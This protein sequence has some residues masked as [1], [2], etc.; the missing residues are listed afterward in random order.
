M[1]DS[2]PIDIH[3]AGTLAGAFA[4]RV[5]RSPGKTAYREFDHGSEAW[6]EYSWADTAALAARWQQGLRDLGL[7][8]GDRVALMLRNCINWIVFDQAALGLGLITVPLYT[9]DRADSMAYI[10]EDC[11]ARVLLIEGEDQWK[12]LRKVATRLSAL[13]AIIS[14]T[15][16]DAGDSGL[17]ILHAPAWL[18]QAGAAFTSIDIE[19]QALAT[20]VYTSGTTGHPKGVMLSHYNILWNVQAGLARLP[21][22]LDDE[23]LSFLPLSHTFERTG[24]YYLTIVSGSTVSF[25]RSVTLLAEDLVNIR[26]TI[27]IAVPRIFERIYTRLQHKLAQGPG[28]A[29]RLFATAV[30]TGWR[31]FEHQQ[32]R[33][34][35]TP[36]L[37]LWPLWD[38]LVARKVR[39]RLGG[40]LKVAVSG[41]AA[42]SPDIARTFI[43]LGIPIVQGYGLTETSPIVSGNRLENNIPASVGQPL[44]GVEVR[45]AEQNELLV[46]SPSVMLGYWHNEK[47][48]RDIIDAEG[49]FHTGDQARIGNQGHIF[50]TGRIKE[51]IVMSN[52]EKVP[53]AD[54]EVAIA[55][56]PLIEQVMIVGESRPFLAALAVL[57]EEGLEILCTEL[58]LDPHNPEILQTPELVQEVLVRIQH[59]LRDFPG[60]A[61]LHRVV[62]LETPWT[63]EN[64]MM[65]PTLKLRR[66]RVLEYHKTM[67][68]NLYAG[69]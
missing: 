34:R 8:P 12:E 56:D 13:Q 14:I 37:L 67:I 7:Q 9:N 24:G 63:V 36:A 21:F 65:T 29:R 41:G 51:V 35:W 28:L 62:L 43:G 52:G 30:K 3:E 44:D 46:R 54:I 19:P 23:L 57:N 38:A 26:P 25:A 33:A 55:L 49:W 27:L 10:L 53:P 39:A 64:N 42:L 59:G 17:N 45:I 5:A 4:A 16:I 50:I 61:R 20:I 6:R 69:H 68:D 48:T 2:H 66:N 47:A 32:G 11:G 40:R 18:P 1:T 58:E 22:G 31:R 15:P 60:Y